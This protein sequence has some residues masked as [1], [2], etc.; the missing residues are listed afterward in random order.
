MRVVSFWLALCSKETSKALRNNRDGDLL[1]AMLFENPTTKQI[2]PAPYIENTPQV[3]FLDRPTTQ[4][5]YREIGRAVRSGDSRGWGWLARP[6]WRSYGSR[7]D[8]HAACWCCCSRVLCWRKEHHH[9]VENPKF[10][11]MTEGLLPAA[12]AAAVSA[13]G[14][15][16]KITHEHSTL[17]PLS[18]IFKP[19]KGCRSH[20]SHIKHTLALPQAPD[21]PTP[22][23]PPRSFVSC[24]L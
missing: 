16:T 5:P 13:K 15:Q 11:A 14:E 18:F 20:L 9:D 22:D 24:A 19:E 23:T 8:G 3:S 10:P 17:V 12:A 1:S 4:H 2:S 7:F 21:L 6:C